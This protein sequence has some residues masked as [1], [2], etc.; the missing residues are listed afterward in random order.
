M[1]N[2]TLV[3]RLTKDPDVRYTNEQMCVARFTVAVNRIKKDEADFISCVSFGK[4][5]EFIE[6]YFIK[7]SQ[8]GIVGHIQT[9]SYEKN[10]GS[11]V[12]TTDVIIDRAEFVGSKGEKAESSNQLDGFTNLED[13]DMPF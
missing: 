7:G 4:T 9:G 6:K 12:Y 3:G 1:N 13:D 10:D 8:I 5:A 11:K 2:V